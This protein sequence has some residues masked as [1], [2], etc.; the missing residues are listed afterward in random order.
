MN[1]QQAKKLFDEFYEREER[2]AAA[3]SQEDLA[4]EANVAISAISK[5]ERGETT[6]RPRSI[7]AIAAAL[8]VSVRRLT[9]GEK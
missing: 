2:L 8:D 3:M 4:A 9:R 7:R 5:W 6:P 1:E